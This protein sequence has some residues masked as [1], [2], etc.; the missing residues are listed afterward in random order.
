MTLGLVCGRRRTITLSNLLDELGEGSTFQDGDVVIFSLKRHLRDADDAALIRSS[1][2][3]DDAFVVNI[4]SNDAQLKL[5][6]SHWGDLVLR[7]D[8]DVY[9]DLVLIP[10]AEPE[11]PIELAL[12]SDVVR[13][14]VTIST[15]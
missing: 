5:K 2:D 13:A 6:S 4:G 9:W 10:G 14:P 1:S 12:E 15:T 11:D 8:T 3:T 7:E